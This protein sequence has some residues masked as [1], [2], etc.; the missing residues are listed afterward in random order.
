MKTNRIGISILCDNK[1]GSSEILHKTVRYS[2][3]QIQKSPSSRTIA[4]T[5]KFLAMIAKKLRVMAG[6]VDG[7]SHILA[8]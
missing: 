3:D 4:N 8:H 2:L 5:R 7:V 6:V 1:S